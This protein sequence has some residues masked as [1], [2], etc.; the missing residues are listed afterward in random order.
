MLLY[1]FKVFI[2][3]TY[4]PTNQTYLWGTENKLCYEYQGRRSRTRGNFGTNTGLL[5]WPWDG[6][7]DSCAVTR[8]WLSA[9]WSHSSRSSTFPCPQFCTRNWVRRNF[10]RVLLS[11]FRFHFGLHAYLMIHLFI[12]I[13]F[14]T[15]YAVRIEKNHK[16]HSTLQFKGLHIFSHS[17]KRDFIYYTIHYFMI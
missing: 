6:Q 5:S 10:R 1:Y 14:A 15:L 2:L 11:S 16:P 4:F 9:N 12:D 17:H 3:S 13:S 7:G 8:P